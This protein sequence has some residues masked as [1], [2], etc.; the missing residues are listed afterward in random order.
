MIT[1]SAH[2][3]GVGGGL[4]PSRYLSDRLGRDARAVSDREIASQR[5][6]LTR[7]WERV[8]ASCGPA[9]GVRAL[10]D[11]AAMPLFAALGFRASDAVFDRGVAQVH[12][13]TRSGADVALLV[14]P[15]AAR[16]STAWRRAVRASVMYDASWCFVFAPPFL[17]LV[18]TGATGARS[19]RRS[20]DFSFP[21]ALGPAGL[22]VLT[23]AIHSDAFDRASDAEPDIDRLVKSAGLFQDRVRSDLERGVVSALGTL[24]PAIRQMSRHD[25][26]D[27]AL[28]IVYRVLFL[29]FAESR[30]LV[31]CR[32]PIYHAYAVGTLCRMAQQPETAR[33]LWDALAAVTR[34]SRTGCRV[35]D[36]IV[37]PFNGRLFARAA[38]PTLERPS[39]ARRAPGA[40]GA[41]D[42]AMQQ[43]LTA[44]A[45]R[46]T[47]AGRQEICYADLGVEQ[48]GAVYE[49]VLDLDRRAMESGAAPVP[50]LQSHRHSDRRKQSGTF[51]TPQDLAEFVVRRTLAPLVAGRSS[52][53]ILSLRVLDPSMGSGAF[54][55][56][57]CHYLAAAYERALV[58]E[59][60]CSEADVGPSEQVAIRRLIAE[61][62]LAGVDI[63][64]VAVQLARLSL[65][66]ATLAEGKPLG[67]LDHQLRVG[68]SLIG[69][70]PDD[71]RRVAT[72]HVRRRSGDGR[73]PL[74]D[75]DELQRSLGKMTRPLRL[76]AT[77]RSDTAEDVRA[78]ERIWTSL[79]GAHSPL[80]PWRTAADLWCA[81]WFWPE[82]RP[83]TSAEMR[84]AIDAITKID[85]TLHASQ[86]GPWIR[87]AE[88]A[89]RAHGFFH[90]PLEFADVFYD[91]TGGPRADSGFDAVV[92]NPPWE[93]LR[94]DASSQ[95]SRPSGALVRFIRQSALYPSCGRGHVNLY[96]PFL[97]RALTLT[98]PGGRVGLV[99]PWGLA[100]DDGAAELR[101]RLLDRSSVDT[102]VGLDN[103]HGMFPIHRGL[104]FMVL[105]ASPG[106]STDEIR[107][108][109]GVRTRE[110]IAA[111]SSDE[112]DSDIACYPIRLSRAM[113]ARASGPARRIPD[114]RR[115]EALDL[116]DRLASRHP[117]L[118][119][120]SGWNVRFGRELNITEDR[121]HF[122]ARGLPV[123]E[124]KHVHPFVVDAASAAFRIA[125]ATA[126]R[127]L[128]SHGF[129]RPRLAYR[130]VSG[131]SNR[132]SLIA[133]IVP[134][135]S[136]TSHTL[137]CLRTDLPIEQQH[138]LCGLF[139]SYVLNAIVRMLMGGHL[140]T[141][142]VETLPVPA[143]TG[144]GAQRRVARLGQKL[145]DGRRHGFTH[146]LL[147]G[148]V[149]RM[150]ELDRREFQGVLEGFPLVPAHDRGRALRAFERHS[151]AFAL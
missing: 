17:S 56:A 89:A 74:F 34:L 133:A 75:D 108:R 127:L 15:W 148:A 44:L 142:L 71:L 130:D 85:P 30:D 37:R 115:R 58:D 128:P 16:P 42:R 83:P 110:E 139:N 88:T 141:S 82:R 9:T 81:R 145:A 8:A 129:T 26:F 65:W 46:D 150:Y 59:A 33:G 31:P 95:A 24:T 35:D 52:D 77:R 96:Q 68:N 131:V 79:A 124:G 13:R 87:K 73:L 138:F 147:Q 25:A 140:T 12:L 118:A 99:L 57:A 78:K 114:V 32:H 19:V 151:Q 49:R 106:G 97:E 62:C 86:I 5:T 70:S 144:S 45:T 40:A 1:P 112:R 125:R 104:R 23:R 137:F 121:P 90:W 109:F 72:D 111:L 94:D 117:R 47:A 135:G 54:L 126:E 98:R 27:E 123:L 149:A 102:I 105:V 6:R 93:M 92:G 18:P 143:W 60:R 122:G 66:L 36:L 29:L 67:F 146:A 28:T 53:D 51:Y 120:A 116:L 76:I 107:A 43:T 101:A 10:F 20:L 100:V 3:N 136:V 134:A 132:L 2:I 84:A 103:A 21:A 50:R 14:L 69:A 38:A 119:S 80:A 39:S 7:W 48:L 63:N 4:F 113:L 61:R 55:V 11:V 41:H 22:G 91:E 64:P